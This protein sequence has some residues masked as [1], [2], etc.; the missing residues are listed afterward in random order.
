MVIPTNAVIR[1]R[2]CKTLYGQTFHQ[3]DA[4]WLFVAIHTCGVCGGTADVVAVATGNVV[5]DFD[6]T[7]AAYIDE[8]EIQAVLG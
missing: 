1:C 8:D 5:V 7:R 2:E 6:A 3:T 4:T